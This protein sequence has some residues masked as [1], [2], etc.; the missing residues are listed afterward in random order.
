L[1]GGIAR[2]GARLGQSPGVDRVDEDTRAGL[3]QPRRQAG[4]IAVGVGQ[5]DGL[6]VAH[7]EAELPKVGLE[8]I[9]IAGQTRVDGGEAT[10]RSTRYQFTMGVPRR[11]TPGAISV[12]V[13][14]CFETGLRWL[15]AGIEREA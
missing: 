13:V 11:K 7:G 10:P 5:D 4:V 14:L 1:A 9:A 15:L 8:A 3:A 12:I 2:L 6:D